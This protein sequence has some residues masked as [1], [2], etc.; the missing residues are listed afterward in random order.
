MWKGAKMTTPIESFSVNECGKIDGKT[1]V[2]AYTDLYLDPDNPT[3]VVLDTTWGEVHLD[4]KD[5]V[6]NGETITRLELYPTDAPTVL[7]FHREDGGIDCITGEELSKIVYLRY[8]ADVEQGHTLKNG[9][10]LV[11]NSGTDTFNYYDLLGA[12][13]TINTT[14]NTLQNMVNT[15]QGTVASLSNSLANLTTRVNAIEAKLVPPTGAPNDAR[16]SWGN[17]NLYSDVNYTGSNT[18]SKSK[19]LYTHDLSTSVVGDEVFS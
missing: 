5:V 12:L 7:R 15:L 19:G 9:E 18:L 6:K 8:L 2:N 17:I 4:L 10:V 13:G 1:R 11:Y 16:I 14:I 3:G